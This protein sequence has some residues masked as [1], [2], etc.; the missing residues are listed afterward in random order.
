ML[1]K[2]NFQISDFELDQIKEVVNIGAS[3]ASTAL[4]QLTKR[5]INITVPEV[6][7]SRIESSADYIGN[8]EKIATTVLLKILGDTTGIMFFLFPGDSG[9]RLSRLITKSQDPMAV[10]SEYDRSALQEIGNILSGACLTA[11]SRFLGISMLHSVAE[12][13]TDMLGSIIN[14]VMAE[15]GR[16]ADIAL[17]FKVQMTVENENITTQLFFLADPNFTEEILKITKKKIS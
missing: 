5:R 6:T 4:N 14:S 3:Y 13:A 11:L 2:L 16:E 7:I 17:I 12:V 1:K 15:V 9:L 8:S 10:L